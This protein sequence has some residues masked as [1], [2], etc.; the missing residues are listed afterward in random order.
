MKATINTFRGFLFLFFLVGLSA[1]STT[2]NEV[3]SANENAYRDITWLT[4][5]LQGEGIFVA[6]K[7]EA[8]SNIIADISRRL[9]LNG[10]EYV[11]AY[12][13][14]N[15]DTAGA[16]AR[17]YASSNPRAMVFVRESL[18]VVRYSD[19]MSEISTALHRYLG[20]TI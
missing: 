16:Q 12:Y 6:E 17:I 15:E 10:R 4:D 13:F 5:E 14:E 3:A 11:D 7:G 9:L 19:S 2:R 8:R 18:I 1:C 20:G